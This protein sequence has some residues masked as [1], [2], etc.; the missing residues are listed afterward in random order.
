MAVRTFVRSPRLS[1]STFGEPAGRTMFTATLSDV[2]R[3]TVIIALKYWRLHR[4]DG[5]V[6]QSDRMLQVA[7]LD[8]LLTKLGGS[9]S[10]MESQGDI[11]RS[12]LSR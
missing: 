1:S 9:Q 10:V 3:E 4:H 7:E 5:G 6:R 8:A 12:L 2:E 11:I